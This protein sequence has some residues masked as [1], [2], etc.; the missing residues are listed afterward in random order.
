MNEGFERGFPVNAQALPENN[1]TNE[2][3]V[4]HAVQHQLQGEARKAFLKIQSPVASYD[5]IV[6]A[7]G[8][9]NA[10]P[11]EDRGYDKY[12]HGRPLTENIDRELTYTHPKGI[13][14][15]V[16]LHKNGEITVSPAGH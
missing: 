9:F 3:Q 12:D 1:L 11:K 16:T 13:E 6:A 14:Y 5:D 8:E 7:M 2:E 15:V 4:E 10:L